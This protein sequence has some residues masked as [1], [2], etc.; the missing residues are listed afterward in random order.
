[1]KIGIQIDLRNPPPWHR[2]WAR[3][4]AEQL[5]FVEEAD[6]LGADAIWLSEHH[7]FEDGYLPQPLTFGAAVAARTKRARIGTAILLA[8]LRPALQIAE[9]AALIDLISDGRL[10]L[11]VGVG[12]RQ[13]EYLAFGQDFSRRYEV[14]EE[15]IT[16]IRE[17][18]AS[19]VTPPPVQPDIPL[20]G[21]FFGPR[22]ARLAGRLGMGLLTMDPAA[23]SPYLDA[24]PTAKIG[25]ARPRVMAQLRVVV[26]S[27]PERAWSRI[28]PHLEY[29]WNTYNRYSVEG[30]PK[31]VPAPIDAEAW[32]RWSA[33][34]TPPRFQVLDPA[35]TVR[36]IESTTAAVPVDGMYAW[37]SIA[38]MDDDLVEEHMRLLL[39]EVRPALAGPA[40]L[41]AGVGT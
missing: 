20:W 9:D 38:G 28:K 7:F 32:R 1:M 13:P 10:D 40:E 4:L 11:G 37:L 23:L 3:H 26:S 35:E 34:G 27:D 2:P 14:L 12:Y 17:L 33:D 19:R 39:T 24:I 31:P 5:E 25:D 8:G 22:G 21:G 6:R 18:L 29:M 30:T 41:S 15:R 36:F 16:E